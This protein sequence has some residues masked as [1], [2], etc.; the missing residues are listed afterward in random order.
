MHDPDVVAWEIR[1][2]WPR[3]SSLPAT[4]AH[5]GV[6]WQVRHHH[7]HG[8]GCADDPPHPDGA[9]PWWKP[10]SYR[11]FWRLAGRDYYWPPI[12]TVWHHEP[13]GRDALTVCRDRYQGKDGKWHLTTGWRYHF[14]HYHLQF[15]P[16]QKLRRRL[17]T[18]CAWCGGKDAK[19]NSVNHSHSWDGPRGH[20][21]QGEPGLYHGGCSAAA[22]A[23]RTCTC[24]VP[25]ISS[26]GYGRCGA[27]G[28]F[29]PYGIKP[30]Q[31]RRARQLQAQGRP[32]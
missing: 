21:W 2:P 13:G 17:L 15:P 10:S 27:C 29:R 23:D 14:W 8:S 19:G 28:R 7:D 22:E 16:L 1:R 18:R 11:R 4:G 12:L 9:W 31:I 30:E 26:N 20:W 6:R 3:R 5:D 32:R 25:V 24:D